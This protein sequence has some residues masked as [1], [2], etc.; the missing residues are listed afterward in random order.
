MF[1]VFGAMNDKT[2]TNTVKIPKTNTNLNDKL[3][4]NTSYNQPIFFT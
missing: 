4:K 3:E 1:R 2:N